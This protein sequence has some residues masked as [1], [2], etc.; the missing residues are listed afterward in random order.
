MEFSRSRLE[1]E[2][3]SVPALRVAVV[4]RKALA[5]HPAVANVLLVLALGCLVLLYF[6]N[7]REVAGYAFLAGGGLLLLGL[8]AAVLNGLASRQARRQ[9][10]EITF[11]RDTVTLRWGTDE[12]TLPHD[13]LVALRLHFSAEGTTPPALQAWGHSATLAWEGRVASFVLLDVPLNARQVLAALNVKSRTVQVPWWSQPTG[14][15]LSGLAGDLYLI[16][17]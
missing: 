16:F 17:T 12:W 2:T 14:T 13:C 7:N 4:P 10:G 1:P 11:R 6:M 3:E 5:Y 8:G 9:A 15:L